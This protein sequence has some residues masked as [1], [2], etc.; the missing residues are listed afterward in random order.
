MT[1]R[2]K[3]TFLEAPRAKKGYADVRQEWIWGERFHVRNGKVEDRQESSLCGA[4]WRRAGESVFQVGSQPEKQFD[5]E[6]AFSNFIR[7]KV[8]ENQQAQIE[9]PFPE[10]CPEVPLPLLEYVL[11]ESQKGPKFRFIWENRSVHFSNSLGSIFQRADP[12]RQVRI[13]WNRQIDQ[14]DVHLRSFLYDPS[15]R[16]LQ[17]MVGQLEETLHMLN[18]G[19]SFD[20]ETCEVILHPSVAAVLLH[21]TIGHASEVDVNREYATRFRGEKISSA[22]LTV[23]DL[24]SSE[25][26]GFSWSSDDEGIP[27]DDVTLID[28]G[29]LQEPLVSLESAF[30]LDRIPRGRGRAKDF[31]FPAISRMMNIVAQPG[32]SSFSDLLGQVSQGIYLIGSLGAWGNGNRH[33]IQCQYG[34]RIQNGELKE[35]LVRPCLSGDV[36]M[37]LGN[38]RGIADDFTWVSDGGCLSLDQNLDLSG[39]GSPHMLLDNAMI[40]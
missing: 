3:S 6:T 18:D 9:R 5:S 35:P 19:R 11:S 38:I 26:S 8:L 34:F 30:L 37:T 25:L 20:R 27:V 15:L 13:D 7:S 10:E 40:S 31:R 2:K 22:N 1:L 36:L 21:E 33:I 24:A 29:V 28:C 23:R 17:S 32:P 4:V 16:D 39:R 14:G 12:I